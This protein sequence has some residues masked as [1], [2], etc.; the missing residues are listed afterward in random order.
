M[1][2]FADKIIL[3]SCGVQLVIEPALILLG[4]GPSLYM[5]PI[6]IISSVVRV[7]QSRRIAGVSRFISI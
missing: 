6:G 4:D 1:V 3:A 2:K 7:G 5:I